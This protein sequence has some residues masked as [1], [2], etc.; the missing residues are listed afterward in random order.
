MP[1]GDRGDGGESFYLYRTHPKHST[2]LLV[3][4]GR[5]QL[6]GFSQWDMRELNIAQ[7]VHEAQ[8]KESRL[9]HSQVLEDSSEQCP[10]LKQ[11]AECMKK[12]WL[13]LKANI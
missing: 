10:L 13:V 7:S 5:I 4:F 2:V 12:T 3:V 1:R 8:V 11:G 6:S 9:L